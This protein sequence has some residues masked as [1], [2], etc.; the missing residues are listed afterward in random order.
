MESKENSVFVK[1]LPTFVSERDIRAKFEKYG[2]IVN[3]KIKQGFCFIDYSN[4]ISAK[5]AIREMNGRTFDGIEI[6]VKECF[7]RRNDKFGGEKRTP[8]ATDRCKNC[9]QL[10]HWGF[11]C[12]NEKKM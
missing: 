12:T 3:I 9:Q 6:E 11:Q 10:G 7:E 5:E 1:N 4:T 8:K 2:E